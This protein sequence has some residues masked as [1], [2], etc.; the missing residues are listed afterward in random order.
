MLKNL[1]LQSRL[2][3]ATVLM[4]LFAGAEVILGRLIGLSVISAD[5]INM[6]G[7]SLLLFIALAVDALR[8][9]FDKQA[10]V[11]EAIGGLIGGLF[12]I[13]MGIMM[14]FGAGH[15]NH[16]L[17]EHA[18]MMSMMGASDFCGISPG[19]WVSGI[20]A[21]SFVLHAGLA[22]YLLK[23]THNL[24]VAG[25]C[26]HFGI[27][28]LMTALMFVSG[29]LMTWFGLWYLS[30]LLMFGITALMVVSGARLGY[31]SHKMLNECLTKKS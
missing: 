23:D 16:S 19:Y 21:F 22:L 26:L 15:H 10:K 1:T 8:R 30:D 2:F 27:T 4:L 17:A 12:L 14:A 11:L 9:V 3:I 13:G 18:Q 24:N 29:F 20:A 6:L 31:K 7:H 25:A 28:T 5:G